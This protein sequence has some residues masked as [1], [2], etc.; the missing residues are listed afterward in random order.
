MIIIILSNIIQNVFKWIENFGKTIIT[1]MCTIVT[2]KKKQYCLLVV[3]IIN[4]INKAFRCNGITKRWA[5]NCNEFVWRN[6]TMERLKSPKT[7]C[8]LIGKQNSRRLYG[9][10][11]IRPDDKIIIILNH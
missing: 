10:A 1:L 11:F 2:N 7:I 4:T 5:S 9:I 3:R 6:L 8:K